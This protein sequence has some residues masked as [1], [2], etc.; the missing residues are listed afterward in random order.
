MR[1]RNFI[2][3]SHTWECGQNWKV[4]DAYQ[5][6]HWYESYLS[7]SYS[8]WYWYIHTYLPS[9]ADLWVVHRLDTPAVNHGLLP[10][11]F[12]LFLLDKAAFLFI[13]QTI[14]FSQ[15]MFY[16]M[17]SLPQPIDYE[18]ISLEYGRNGLRS[19]QNRLGDSRESHSIGVVIAI[20]CLLTQNVSRLVSTAIRGAY[21]LSETDHISPGCEGP[22]NTQERSHVDY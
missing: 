13:L 12:K 2:R 17:Q 7:R 22:Q 3:V 21:Y 20:T 18:H 15:G 1:V 5:I 4:A 9:Y 8:I 6:S 10:T 19:V 14:I 16:T 11:W